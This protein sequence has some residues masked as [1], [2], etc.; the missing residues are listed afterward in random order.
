MKLLLSVSMPT[1]RLTGYRLA[2][3]SNWRLMPNAWS[4]NHQGAP[5]CTFPFTVPSQ[6]PAASTAHV[7]IFMP[8]RGYRMVLGSSPAMV[9][10]FSNSP[11]LVTEH[12]SSVQSNPVECPVRLTPS[13]FASR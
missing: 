10:R 6:K 13:L 11:T 4:L 12:W 2:H 5:N 1:D 8:S 7:S 9:S 3:A